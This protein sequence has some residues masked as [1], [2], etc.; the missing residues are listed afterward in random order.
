MSVST[1]SA[2]ITCTLLTLIIFVL[3]GSFISDIVLHKRGFKAYIPSSDRMKIA[4]HIKNVIKDEGFFKLSQEN[5]HQACKMYNLSYKKFHV[6]LAILEEQRKLSRSFE[7][8]VPVAT[9]PVIPVIPDSSER[10]LALDS[11]KMDAE[12]S[13]WTQIS[14]DFTQ[15]KDVPKYTE[16]HY[17]QSK[18]LTKIITYEIDITGNE[19]LKFERTSR[20]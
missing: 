10:R 2:V 17:C 16:V 18:K 13:T 15:V 8:G 12:T 6:L 19:L 1:L 3:L 7:D 5:I 9:T 14:C 4:L 20:R 11:L